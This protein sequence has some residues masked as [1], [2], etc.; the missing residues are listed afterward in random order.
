MGALAVWKNGN[1]LLLP[2]AHKMFISLKTTASS[3]HFLLGMKWNWSWP[4]L[5]SAM[6]SANERPMLAETNKIVYLLSSKWH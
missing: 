2:P 1:N 4:W 5:P 3:A 6:Y